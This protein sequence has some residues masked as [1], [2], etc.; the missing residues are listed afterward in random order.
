MF[1]YLRKNDYFCKPKIK[2]NK[3][4]KIKYGN[5]KNIPTF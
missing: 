4:D 2:N 5:E 3:N 1:G